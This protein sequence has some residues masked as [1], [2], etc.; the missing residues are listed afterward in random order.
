MHSSAA[1]IARLSPPPKKWVVDKRLMGVAILTEIVAV[2][3]A[4]MA[5]YVPVLGPKLT[6]DEVT[7]HWVAAVVAASIVVVY[8][9]IIG[10]LTVSA[11]RMSARTGDMGAAAFTEADPDVRTPRIPRSLLLERTPAKRAWIALGISLATLP[12][13]IGLG[14]SLWQIWLAILAPWAPIVVMESR[15]K[16]A[17]HAV[18]ASFGLMV[19]LQCLH[20]VEHST[21]IAQLAIT[22]GTLAD[23]HG[24][25]G[26]L[27][28]ETV[29]FVADSA[30]WIGL[31]LLAIIFR[32]RN[33]WLLVAFVAASLHE[34][35]HLYLFWMYT[36][37]HT[38]Y[39]SGGA[40]GILGHYG[41]IGSPLDR[42]YLHYTYNFVVFVPLLIA[43]WDQAREMDR[44]R[45]RPQP[46]SA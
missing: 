28:F 4:Y 31:G 42:P 15:Y 7:R 29:H 37:D 26:E 10:C 40:A 2:A 18:F 44:Q 25:I 12:V 27:D 21:Q 3:L 39:L 11:R 17:Y 14:G 1:D 9:V 46:Q 16:Y 24:V 6:P 23:S 38:M 19:L 35:E 5:V 32:G 45:P 36:T 22:G 8:G 43:F 41:L 30:L 34:I 13:T 33:V 20:M